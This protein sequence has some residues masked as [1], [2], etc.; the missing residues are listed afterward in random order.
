MAPGHLCLYAAFLPFNF[1]GETLDRSH[2][3]TFLSLFRSFAILAPANK[4]HRSSIIYFRSSLQ[5]TSNASIEWYIRP[6]FR[7]L[8]WRFCLCR[9]RLADEK[10]LSSWRSWSHFS[11]CKWHKYF[12]YDVGTGPDASGSIESKGVEHYSFHFAHRSIIVFNV[13]NLVM[14]W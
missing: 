3:T 1:G 12:L 10:R 4:R 6:T 14:F 8:G 9:N 11:L 13:S 5:H 7:T 2:T